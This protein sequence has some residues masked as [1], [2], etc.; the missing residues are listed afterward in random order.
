MKPLITLV[1]IAAIG[2]L[3]Y[4]MLQ[5]GSKDSARMSE[6]PKAVV[7]NGYR[8]C[9]LA[10]YRSCLKNQWFGIVRDTNLEN[11][12]PVARAA[13]N[14]LIDTACQPRSD[15]PASRELR[16]IDIKPGQRLVLCRLR[17]PDTI[18]RGK[19]LAHAENTPFKGML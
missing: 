10:T 14:G 12:N 1:A 4:V 15:P 17:D 7:E 13:T 9:D 5:E 2:Y 19:M 6:W 8:Y 11:Q 16:G 3:G 18:D